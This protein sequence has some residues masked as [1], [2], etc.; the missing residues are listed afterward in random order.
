[1]GSVGKGIESH[2]A[3]LCWMP[4]NVEQTPMSGASEPVASGDLIVGSCL[5]SEETTASRLYPWGW[6]LLVVIVE[7]ATS[8]AKAIPEC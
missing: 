6:D 2:S 8:C 3:M 1:M 5:T 7:M 4:V